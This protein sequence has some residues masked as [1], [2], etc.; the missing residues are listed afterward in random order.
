MAVWSPC[1]SFVDDW[2]EI[3]IF[4]YNTSVH[5]CTKCTPYELVFDELAREPL[6]QQEKLQIYDD[7]LINFVTQLHE[8]RTPAIENLIST[9]EKSKIY[10][11]KKLIF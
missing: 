9:K 1:Y 4:S 2:L 6:L 5:E 11:D 8:I 3:G 7:Y 10:Y